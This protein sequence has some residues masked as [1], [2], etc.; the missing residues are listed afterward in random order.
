MLNISWGKSVEGIHR[1][2]GDHA[3][4]NERNS[5]SWTKQRSL[6]L[7]VHLAAPEASSEL[8]FAWPN[9]S[10][11]TFAST[12]R[13]KANAKRDRGSATSTIVIECLPSSRL[14]ISPSISA[15]SNI[16]LSISSR[17]SENTHPGGAERVKSLGVFNT[18][19]TW[20]HQTLCQ[21]K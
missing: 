13:R 16:V 18:A 19:R 5:C 6:S 9:A 7:I 21:Y 15:L 1:R 12:G 8:A 3:S 4:N 14:G 20:L 10:G 2:G 17:E 11:R